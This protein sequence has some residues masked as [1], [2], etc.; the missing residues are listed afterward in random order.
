MARDMAG[1]G[2]EAATPPGLSYVSDHDPG[3]RRRKAGVGF[4]YFDPEGAPV[5]DEPTLDRIRALAIPPA[6]PPG[7]AACA[8][9]AAA[10]ETRDHA[11]R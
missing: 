6:P 7:T 8:G 10:R 3:I 5:T 1:T 2:V 4:N 9:A 11:R